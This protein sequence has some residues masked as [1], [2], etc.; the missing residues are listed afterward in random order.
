MFNPDTVAYTSP[1]SIYMES[2][3]DES[4]LDNFKDVTAAIDASCWLHKAISLSLSP[5]G[6]ERSSV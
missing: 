2:V 4:N 6:D 5:Y 3:T 1:G